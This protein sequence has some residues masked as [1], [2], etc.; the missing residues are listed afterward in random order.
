M[1]FFLIGGDSLKAMRVVLAI[2]QQYDARMSLKTFFS[3]STLAEQSLWLDRH[4]QDEGLTSASDSPPTTSKGLLLNHTASGP[5]FAPTIPPAQPRLG[6]WAPDTRVFPASFAQSRLWFL[7]QVQPDLT[8]YQIPLLW[9][10][11]GP[12]DVAALAKALAGLIERHPTLRTS[13]Q[14]HDGNDVVQI[15]HPPAPFQLHPEPLSQRD[16]EAVLQAWQQQEAATPF[17][18]SSGILLRARLLA[19]TEQEHILLINHHLTPAPV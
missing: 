12:L 11:R 3:C 14:L 8:A 16:P 5:Q 13:F 4:I 2:A 19:V 1:N 10:L 9:R 18:L 15:L 6:D 17:D 7:Q